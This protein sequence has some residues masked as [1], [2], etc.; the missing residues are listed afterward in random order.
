MVAGGSF[1]ANT[2]VASCCHPMVCYKPD[3]HIVSKNPKAHTGCIKKQSP[4]RSGEVRDSKPDRVFNTICFGHLRPQSA[5]PP[6][7]GY[8]AANAPW[9]PEPSHRSIIPT[10]CRYTHRCR[11]P[12]HQIPR[13]TWNAC[14]GIV[15]R[16]TR[17][18]SQLARPGFPRCSS[19]NCSES[20]H[21][22]SR[23]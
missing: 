18:R 6:S 1:V 15:P 2:P 22:H 10:R 23:G 5:I 21:Y 20:R 17:C 9:F 11:R 3:D 14:A 19:P 4:P 16:R 8:S 12:G 13:H 7:F